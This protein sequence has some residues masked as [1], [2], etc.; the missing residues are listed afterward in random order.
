MAG[1][2]VDNGIMPSQVIVPHRP[3]PLIAVPER[4]DRDPADRHD[5]GIG[6]PEIALSL[7]GVGLL[8]AEFAAGLPDWL[9]VIAVAC[10]ALGIV[11]PAH[12]ALLGTLRDRAERRRR[13]ALRQG[14]PLDLTDVSV[15][16]LVAAYERLR[17]TAE[18]GIA[19]DAGHLAVVEVARLLDGRAPGTAQVDYVV[20]RAEAVSTLADR[21]AAGPVSPIEVAD[22]DAL[23][24]IEAL[25]A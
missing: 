9:I 13:E 14:T 23:T 25:L 1:F 4:N 3:G 2:R 18:P 17:R 22:P 10:L 19:L 6:I 20:R 21:V 8:A 5:S 16:R 15:R 12:A 11:L 7:V 24:R